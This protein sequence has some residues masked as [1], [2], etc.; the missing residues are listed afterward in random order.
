MKKLGLVSSLVCAMSM[1]A[2]ATA[3]PASASTAER[4]SCIR[5]RSVCVWANTGFSGNSWKVG[6][7][8]GGTCNASPVAGKSVA[9]GRGAIIRFYDKNNCSGRYFDIKVNDYSSSTPFRVLS[10]R[11]KPA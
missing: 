10:F 1:A 11:V 2:V 5:E 6:D 8:W 9:Q 3:A 7:A 4:D